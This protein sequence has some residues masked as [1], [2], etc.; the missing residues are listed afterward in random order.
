M[1]PGT[2]QVVDLIEGVEKRAEADVQVQQSDQAAHVWDG[3]AHEADVHGVVEP[4]SGQHEH[5]ERVGGDAEQA[6]DAAEKNVVDHYEH[7]GHTITQQYTGVI[8]VHTVTRCIEVFTWVWVR[9]RVTQH[10]DIDAV[11]IDLFHEIPEAKL[12]EADKLKKIRN[13]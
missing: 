6:D 9:V 7:M 4:L 8:C 12:K 1:Q 13:K 2:E 11:I 3:H 10:L 5:V